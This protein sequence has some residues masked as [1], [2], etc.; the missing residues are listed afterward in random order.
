MLERR[1]ALDLES[2]EPKS[3]DLSH[4]V[5]AFAMLHNMA[6]HVVS[7]AD[8]LIADSENIKGTA[9]ANVELL[10]TSTV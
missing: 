7:L 10:L 9:F 5:R 4:P 8:E 2:H 3:A 1:L 6:H